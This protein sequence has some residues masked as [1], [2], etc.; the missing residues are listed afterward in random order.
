MNSDTIF[1][2]LAN[3]EGIV[4]ISQNHSSRKGIKFTAIVTNRRLLTRIKQTT[5]CCYH[6]SSYS[7]IS[8]ESIHR[9][10]E[11]RVRPNTP[12]YSVFWIFW[13]LAAIAGILVS[14]YLAKDQTI[15]IVGII[16]STIPVII[17]SI[18]IFSCLCC[19]FKYKFIKLHGTFGSIEILLEKEEARTFEAHL[20]EQISQ[21]KLYLQQASISTISPPT[22][23]LHKEKG[24]MNR[25]MVTSNRF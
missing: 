18:I 5:C 22:Y 13:L 21:V 16:V 20:S 11:D 10:D 1:R 9:I 14:I 17:M 24:T 6:H 8:L 2:A 23:Y 15:K 25:Q 19:R 4:H 12:L 7:A 3:G